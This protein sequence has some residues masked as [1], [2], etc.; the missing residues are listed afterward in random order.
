MPP[1]DAAGGDPLLEFANTQVEYLDVLPR[2][3]LDRRLLLGGELYLNLLLGV[4]HDASE[5][6]RLTPVACGSMLPHKRKGYFVASL[7][8]GYGRSGIAG[9]GKNPS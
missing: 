5:L 4:G 9:A 7:R 6:D 3:H 2:G 1:S 8:Q